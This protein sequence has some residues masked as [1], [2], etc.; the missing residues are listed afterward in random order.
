MSKIGVI[1]VG[2]D[3]EDYAP[4][5]LAAWRDARAGNLGGNDY[6][7]CCVNVPFEGFSNEE[8]DSTRDILKEALANDEIDHLIMSDTPM[9]ETEARSA[10]L[11]WLKDQGV[12][13]VLQCDSDE[14]WQ[15]DQI[16]RVFAFMGANP[17]VAWARVCYKNYVFDDKTY[18][19]EPF[20]PPRLHRIHLQ[21]GFTAYAF[22]QDNDIC[23]TG[24]ITR[25]VKGQ[26]QF[27]SVII[28]Q[29]CAF[30]PHF[31]WPNSPRSKAKI[32]YQVNGRK[33]ASCSFAWDN[34]KG[35]IFNEAHYKAL[36]QPL[37]ETA[38]DE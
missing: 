16:E 7:I 31:S 23:Y 32:D 6:T 5:S 35:L 1:W 8:Q 4:A 36:G 10:A 26:E 38:R 20:T 24:G 22:N 25:D 34:E 21:G 37:P 29:S 27:A 2:W 30:V 9:K 28:P 33:W 13:I 18:L 15:Q 14:L 17:F 12:E 3:T 11:R 19:V